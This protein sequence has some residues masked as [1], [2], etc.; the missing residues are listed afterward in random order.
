M[1]DVCLNDTKPASV[2]NNSKM[3]EDFNTKYFHMSIPVAKLEASS[4]Y[5]IQDDQTVGRQ[6]MSVWL[7][8]TNKPTQTSTQD[9]LF[10]VRLIPSQLSSGTMCADG[11]CS[12]Q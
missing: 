1:Y 12:R 6:L 7:Y 8:P 3:T 10:N 9:Q 4:H 5:S 2:V 11:K